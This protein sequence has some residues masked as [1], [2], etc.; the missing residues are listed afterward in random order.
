LDGLI[1]IAKCRLGATGTFRVRFDGPF[2]KFSDYD[3]IPDFLP[4]NPNSAGI[5]RAGREQ[6]DNPF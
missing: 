1:D 3:P 2:N 4:D 6:L 5:S